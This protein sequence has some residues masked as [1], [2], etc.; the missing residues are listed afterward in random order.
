MDYPYF[1]FY[2][3]LVF[4]SYWYWRGS[5]QNA[6]FWAFFLTFL[7]FALRAPVVGADTWEYVRYLTGE[8]NFYNE[9]PRPLEPLFVYY[10]E[11]VCSITNSRFLVM[12]IN[13]I[14]SC[15][16]LWYITKKY[17]YN[18]PLTLLLFCFFECL[19]VYFIG[20]RQ[21]LALSVLYLS[22][23]YWVQ[24]EGK[25][26][27]KCLL[28]LLCSLTAFFIHTSSV[29]YALLIAITFVPVK[30]SKKI[31]YIVIIGSALVG[32][33]FEKFNVLETFAIISAMAFSSVERLDNYLTNGELNDDMQ[34]NI[35]LRITFIALFTIFFLSKEKISHP[36]CK[37]FVIAVTMF[38][39]LFSVPMVHRLVYPLY[40]F[41]AIV[42]SWLFGK[43]Y[44]S[45]SIYRY[46]VNIVVIFIVLYF[47]RSNYINLS[48]YDRTADGRMHPYFF[49]FEDYSKHPS[50]IY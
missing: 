27:K 41:G 36:F 14:L 32:I 7:F 42:F 43:E 13:T 28:F 16:P 22:L 23:I 3:I 9:D 4:L 35:L 18:P 17:S 11:L 50:I 25:Y 2:L 37:I 34:I 31:Y 1:C 8:R 21:I 44:N 24:Q 49:I 46:R 12:I 10:R 26:I 20:L 40:F 30:I 39:L 38:N 5:K 29:L 6:T 15:F 48:T 33:V 45:K 19:L 47:M